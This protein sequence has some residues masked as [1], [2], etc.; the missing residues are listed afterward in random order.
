M[1]AA[2]MKPSGACRALIRQFEGC[3]L[4]AYLCPAGVVT[5]GTGHT[6]GVKLGDRCSQEQADLWLSQ[7]LEDAAAAVATLVHV[8][9]T[10]GQFDALVSF[11]FNFGASKFRTSTLLRM[12]NDGRPFAAAAQFKLWVRA[13]GKVEPGLVKRRAAEEAMFL[14]AEVAS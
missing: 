12:L 5:I 10:Q 8:P 2:E 3:R 6:K 14:G 13:D 9:L 11:V 4:Q 7:D 1:N